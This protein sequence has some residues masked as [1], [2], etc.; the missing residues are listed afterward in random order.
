MI[1]KNNDPKTNLVIG[2]I[3]LLLSSLALAP[4]VLLRWRNKHSAPGRLI[5]ARRPT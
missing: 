1:S 3:L 2:G 5:V 4:G